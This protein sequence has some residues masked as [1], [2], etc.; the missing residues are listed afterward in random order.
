MK[1]NTSQ[2]QLPFGQNP[3]PFKKGSPSIFL[4][5]LPFLF[6]LPSC[7]STSNINKENPQ[8][9]G[10]IF[11]KSPSPDDDI[12]CF[13]PSP[14]RPKIIQMTYMGQMPLKPYQLNFRIECHD[15][16]KDLQGGNY[17][18]YIEGKAQKRQPLDAR[19]LHHRAKEIFDLSLLLPQKPYP[20]ESQLTIGLLI[21][22][23]QQRRS[24]FYRLRLEAH[25]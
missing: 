15:D 21:F 9:D 1:A 11:E 10:G 19:Q 7:Q 2:R 3:S 12:F 23:A 20:Q 16:G 6:I 24:N 25:K 18:F 22:D 4:L 8:V 17:Q 5:L 13:K 14:S